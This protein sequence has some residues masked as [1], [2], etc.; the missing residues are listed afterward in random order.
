MKVG[1][2]GTRHGMTIEQRSTLENLIELWW[3]SV[4]YDFHHGD[5]VGADEQAAAIFTAQRRGEII[6]HPPIDNRLRAW[7]E[8][9]ILEPKPYLDRNRD[10]VDA[11]DLLIVAP[12]G[13]REAPTGR[14]WYTA[15]YARS[16]RVP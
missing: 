5:C 1:F 14:T 4:M 8:G 16:K 3:P 13:G 12:G 10:I 9:T 7:C 2:T 6:V 11:S 15:R